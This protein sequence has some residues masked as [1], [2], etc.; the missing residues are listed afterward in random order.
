MLDL[1]YQTKKNNQLIVKDN[2]YV[3]YQRSFEVLYIKFTNDSITVLSDSDQYDGSDIQIKQYKTSTW[4][5]LNDIFHDMTNDIVYRIESQSDR[6][7]ENRL[8][9][10]NQLDVI[11]NFMDQ[12]I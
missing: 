12:N 2:Y 10:S 5:N 6:Q 8:S 1:V 9:F 11:R 7:D 4:N 3:V